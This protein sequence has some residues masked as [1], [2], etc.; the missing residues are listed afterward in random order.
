[1]TNATT[2]TTAVDGLTYREDLAQRVSPR[3]STMPTLDPAVADTLAV[4]TLGAYCRG[5]DTYGDLFVC[6]RG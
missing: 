6:G 1:M 4:A 5:C 2:T 3:Q